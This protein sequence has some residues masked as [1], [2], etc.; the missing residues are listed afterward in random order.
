MWRNM[1]YGVRTKI[2]LIACHFQNLL[3]MQYYLT[4]ITLL[5][6]R[7]CFCANWHKRATRHHLRFEPM[8]FASVRV[9]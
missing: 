5:L 7:F 2:N 8:I 3:I 6:K 1:R 9:L 4:T